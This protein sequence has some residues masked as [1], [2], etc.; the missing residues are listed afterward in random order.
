MCWTIWGH[1]FE[2][3]E[4]RAV[5]YVRWNENGPDEAEFVVSVG[6]WGDESQAAQRDCVAVLGRCHEGRLGFMLIDASESS[7]SEH[8]FLGRKRRADE[9]R[10]QGLS[11]L[12]FRLL[13]QVLVDDL[14]V[15]RLRTQ[16]ES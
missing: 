9:V 8:E 14:R 12:V 6:E 5:Y 4:A 15:A 1:V 13:D 2:A 11:R 7:F 16:L 3:G 10:G